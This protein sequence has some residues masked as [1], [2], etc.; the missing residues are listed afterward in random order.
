MTRIWHRR[1]GAW[2]FGVMGCPQRTRCH[3]WDAGSVAFPRHWSG[4]VSCPWFVVTWTH[5][6]FR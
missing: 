2:R 1:I 5:E 4:W 6:S 3:R